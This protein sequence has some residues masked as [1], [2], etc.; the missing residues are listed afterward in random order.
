MVE[1]ET[2]QLVLLF[3][4]VLEF[5]KENVAVRLA[6]G[7]AHDT[8]VFQYLYRERHQVLE[9]NLGAL[10]PNGSDRVTGPER[11]L[12]SQDGTKAIYQTLGK[13]VERVAV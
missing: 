13:T 3:G 8:T 2:D 1:G 9:S 11:I 5:V 12:P 4:A 6:D 7:V 10:K